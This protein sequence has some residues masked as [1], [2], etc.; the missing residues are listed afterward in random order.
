MNRPI[1]IILLCLFFPVFV[2][3]QY[4]HPV[5]DTLSSDFHK[6]RRALLRQNMPNNSVAVFFAN[7]VRNRANDVSYVYHQDPDLFYL[8]GYKEPN[9]VLL[10][11]S[12]SFALADGGVCKELFFVQPRDEKK[13]QWN[14]KRLG[15]DRVK[16]RLGLSYVY[17]NHTFADFPV[18]F[19]QFDK[20]LLYDF[21]H[22]VR[23]DVN[24]T[25]D[26]Y[27]LME[28]FRDKASFPKFY[29]KN[30]ASLYSFIKENQDLPV[31]SLKRTI[32]AKMAVSP[33]L[34]LNPVLREYVKASSPEDRIKVINVLPETNIDLYTLDKLMASLREVKTEKEID[35]LRKAVKISAIGQ[36][37]VMKAMNPDLSEKE[38]QGIHE[39]VFTKYGAEAVGYPSIIGAGHNGC[40]LHYIDNN[41]QKIEKGELIL[42]DV[43]AEYRGYTADVTRTIPVSGK[44]SK[45]QRAIY[46]IVY[47]AQEAAMKEYVIGNE[48]SDPF[49]A[50][51]KVIAKGLM[52]LGIITNL[53]DYR[54]YLPH[55]ITH[56][57]GLDVHDKSNYG[58]FKENMVLT[59]EPG[60]YIPE[61]SPCD[62]K[63]WGIAIRIEDDL[64]VTKQGPVNLSE[65][66][67]RTWKEIE[68]LM[69]QESILQRFILPELD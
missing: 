30:T 31:D 64:L 53:K 60:I 19:N 59:V 2:S 1:L 25:G 38:V 68:K 39:F 32:G 57:I 11:F 34:K 65:D 22:D 36:Q 23:D 56:H 49:K 50:S 9:A 18:D 15:V 67:P 14:G 27:S 7:P 55:G 29:N 69:K 58:V 10:V 12:D 28:Q 17:P 62:A 6:K 44:F 33:L 26:L 48:F 16:E 45:E 61:N 37:E 20:V 5:E 13:E 42:M 24:D 40:V 47:E 43:G 46:Q 4:L 35:L 52:E 3:A 8:T 54:R 63:W 41:K 21:F 66:A 51:A